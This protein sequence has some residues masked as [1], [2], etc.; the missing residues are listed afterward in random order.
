MTAN[1]SITLRPA[2]HDA[3]E[4]LGA[5][6]ARLAWSVSP[7]ATGC[8]TWIVA[9]DSRAAKMLASTRAVWRWCRVERR[10][11][12]GSLPRLSFASTFAG[13]RGQQSRGRA[14]G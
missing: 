14:D 4:L 2:A 10:V 13:M 3:P 6:H 7:G 12:Y 11:P 5:T 9:L 8:S 1:Q